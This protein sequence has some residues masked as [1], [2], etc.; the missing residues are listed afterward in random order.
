M[1]R[2]GS[3]EGTTTG[4][5]A[6]PLSRLVAA[7]AGPDIARLELPIAPLRRGSSDIAREFYR[8]RFNLAGAD[9]RLENAWELGR[10]DGPPPGGASSMACRGL[11]ISRLTASNCIA[12]SRARF[13]PNCWPA[14]ASLS[15]PKI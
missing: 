14:R 11:R 3:I 6:S 9:V 1:Q 15:Q 8:G 4:I 7:F 12:S 10:A 2:V 13:A 5:A